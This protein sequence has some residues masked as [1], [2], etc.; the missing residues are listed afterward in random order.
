MR[1]L[2]S[3]SWLTLSLEQGIQEDHTTFAK[4]CSTSRLVMTEGSDE[5]MT[6]EVNVIMSVQVFQCNPNV[7]TT[8]EVLVNYIIVC[9]YGLKLFTIRCQ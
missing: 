4:C 9:S 6:F 1:V 5:I 2:G 3:V 8:C 7:L